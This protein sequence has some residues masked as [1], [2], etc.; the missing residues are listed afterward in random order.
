MQKT[1]CRCCG[2]DMEGSDHCPKC[3]CEE[4]EERCFTAAPRYD[5]LTGDKLRDVVMKTTTRSWTV[6]PTPYGNPVGFGNAA[7]ESE[8]DGL[9]HRAYLALVGVESALWMVSTTVEEELLLTVED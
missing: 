6:R 2:T 5:P 3:F 7:F 1:Y 8:E 4:Y 9:R